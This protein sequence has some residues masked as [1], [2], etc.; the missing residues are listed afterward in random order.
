MFCKKCG[1][2]LN[3]EARF[4]KKCGTELTPAN[5]IS[6]VSPQSQAS[7]GEFAREHHQAQVARPEA[8]AETPYPALASQ[9]RRS[10]T[11]LILAVLGLVVIVG[12]SYL[13]MKL[14]SK[15]TV[16]GFGD[17][18]TVNLNGVKLE[19][20]RVPGGEFTMGSN[21][22][23]NDE[24]PPHRVKLSAFA[25]GKYEVTQAQWKA[26]MGNNPSH[27]NTS[28]DLPVETVSWDDVQEFLGRLREKTGDQRWRLPTEAEWEYAARAGSQGKYSFGD[29]ESELRNYAW[30]KSN[31]NIQ[32]HPV[33]QLKPNAFGLYDMHGNVWEWC[34]DWS[35]LY[36][37]AEVTDPTGPSGGSFQS[38]RGGSFIDSAVGCRSA[39]RYA[40]R[41]GTRYPYLGFRLLR[42]AK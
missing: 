37:S 14:S 10:Q 25:I 19:M 7:V 21:D 13:A 5:S 29:D 40:D 23:E 26:L 2:Q 28:D 42:T 39:N 11:Q 6:A 4:C 18:F 36:H 22:G 8:Q 12:V 16:P 33:G 3:P 17:A 32:P 34:E 1:T 27:F 35:G 38:E 24:K 41:P 9:P 20:I 30:F 31:S 15:R